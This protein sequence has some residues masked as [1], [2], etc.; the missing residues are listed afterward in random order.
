MTLKCVTDF[1]FVSEKGKKSQ[2]TH[3]KIFSVQLHL[4]QEESRPKNLSSSF[5]EL[6]GASETW[7]GQ[8]GVA[9]AVS[10]QEPRTEFKM[11]IAPF[12]RD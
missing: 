6:F 10:A 9:F 1:F 11:P 5:Q 8:V 7:R 2:P 12:N 4:C 3:F